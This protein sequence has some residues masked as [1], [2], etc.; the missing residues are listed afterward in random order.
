MCKFYRDCF[1]QKN[2]QLAAHEELTHEI[3]CWRCPCFESVRSGK[4]F[5]SHK[6]TG[7]LSREADFGHDSVIRL[8]LVKCLLVNF[9]KWSN[10]I[11]PSL[12]PNKWRRRQTMFFF[13]SWVQFP[14]ST[15]LELFQ[16]SHVELENYSHRDPLEMIPIGY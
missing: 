7:Q 1:T 14:P 3:V 10:E 9:C 6:T 5:S 2:T 13:G 11:L 16:I 8:S 15:I 12:F 4:L